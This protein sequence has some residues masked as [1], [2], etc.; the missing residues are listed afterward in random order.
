MNRPVASLTRI[1]RWPGGAPRLIFRRMNKLIVAL[2]LA[3]PALGQ[4]LEDRGPGVP[5]SMF[6]TYITRGEWI[7]YPFLESYRDDD[8]EY[9]PEE[10][11]AEGDQDFRG[12]YRATEGL[13]FLAYGITDDVA[14][15]FE[16]AFI[17][18]TF[19]KAP[20]DPSALPT[21]IEESGVG[22]V[23]GQIRW[24]ILRETGSRPE[25]F[26]YAE[27][28]FPHDEE[29]VLTGTA[30]WQVKA[31]AGLTRGFRWGTMTARAALEYD[32]ASSSALDL[33]EFAVE[34]LKRL[35]QRWRVYAGI[36]GTSDELALIAELQWHVTPRMMVKLNN[37]FGL[38]SK[39]TD[40]APEVGILFS[41]PTR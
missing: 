22:D 26:S 36:E 14:M 25:M 24:R 20:E 15:E 7:V 33:G 12:R 6:G 18:A 5:T 34:Y 17:D 1:D 16:V 10:L 8:L 31:G 40:Y 30:D 37:G 32:A 38:T 4:H 21:R 41:I 23:E 28:V 9:A 39:A 11:G 35:S 2:L 27:V 3:A 29:K 19:E 13:L